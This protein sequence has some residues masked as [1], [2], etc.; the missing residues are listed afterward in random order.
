MKTTDENKHYYG[1]V[2]FEGGNTENAVLSPSGFEGRLD[3]GL[4]IF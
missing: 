3:E 4:I 2:T 1:W